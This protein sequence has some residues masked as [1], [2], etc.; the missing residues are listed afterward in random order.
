MLRRL[1]ESTLR[2]HKDATVLS[3]SGDSIKA[4]IDDQEQE[5]SGF[6]SIIVAAGRKANDGLLKAMKDLPSSMRVLVAGDLSKP[7]LAIDAIRSATMVAT[8]VLRGNV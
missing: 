3:I 6:D 5:F 2:V 8:Q 1:N 7:A 4:L